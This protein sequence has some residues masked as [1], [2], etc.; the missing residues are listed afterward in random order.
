VGGTQT[1]ER[2]WCQSMGVIYSHS[3]DSPRYHINELAMG[4]HRLIKAVLIEWP[5][6]AIGLAGLAVKPPIDRSDLWAPVHPS[7]NLCDTRKAN[8]SYHSHQHTHTHTHRLRSWKHQLYSLGVNGVNGVIIRNS[9]HRHPYSDSN[10]VQYNKEWQ[11]RSYSYMLNSQRSEHQRVWSNDWRTSALQTVI[12][13]DS[14]I[15]GT[16]FF[17]ESLQWQISTK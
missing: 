4:R 5:M 15:D 9:P 1:A 11:A 7:V 3:R 8:R 16:S 17:H 10:A 14:C 12:L 2:W 6:S 13:N